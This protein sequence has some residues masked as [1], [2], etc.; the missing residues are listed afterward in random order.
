MEL[1]GGGWSTHIPA[2]LLREKTR[3]PLYRRLGRTQDGSE[4]VWI[5][6]NSLPP[7]GL[8]LCTSYYSTDIYVS[9]IQI[10]GYKAMALQIFDAL[11]RSFFVCSVHK[12]EC[13]V[14]LMHV[15]NITTHPLNSRWGGP[16][17]R[18][19]RLGEEIKFVPLWGFEPKIVQPL[20]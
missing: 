2:P 10:F 12:R 3:C 19:G 17:S 16:R 11:K 6:G 9:Q 7:Q 5:K 14:G 15:T 1:F 4:R 20:A 13:K 8:E 18:S